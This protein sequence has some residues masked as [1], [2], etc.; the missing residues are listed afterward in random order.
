MNITTE[1]LLKVQWNMGNGQCPECYG[2]EP[3]FHGPS[4]MMYKEEGHFQDCL[5][6]AALLEQDQEVIYM[7]LNIEK[8]FEGKKRINEFF[9]Y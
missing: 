9:S 7:Q 2:C 1:F 3:G 8:Y 4:S 6:A 5:L